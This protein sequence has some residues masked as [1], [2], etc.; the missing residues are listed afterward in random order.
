M[1]HYIALCR[2]EP[3]IRTVV[4]W[5]S[6][7]SSVMIRLSIAPDADARLQLIATASKCYQPLKLIDRHLRPI[8]N[9]P[10][11]RIAADESAFPTNG[12]GSP[13]A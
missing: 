13:E 2:K 8:C 6:P 3:N 12:N 10:I 7:G 1:L 9:A 11:D 5:H 4:K